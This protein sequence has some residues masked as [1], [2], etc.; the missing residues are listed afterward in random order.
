MIETIKALKY[1]DHF[2][3]LTVGKSK[4]PNFSWKPQQ[5]KKL[6]KE[7][8]IKRYNYRGGQK[9]QSGKEIPETAICI[10]TKYIN[11]LFV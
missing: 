7:E 3:L 11:L 6:S 4:V 9:L 10:E 2:S 1:L 5:T 8:F